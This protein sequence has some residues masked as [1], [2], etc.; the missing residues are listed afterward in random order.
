MGSRVHEPQPDEAVERGVEHNRRLLHCIQRRLVNDRFGS[1][2]DIEA[3]PRHVRFTPKSM[4]AALDHC[5]RS[6]PSATRRTL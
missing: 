6:N 3:S 1:K 5:I 2:A 4:I